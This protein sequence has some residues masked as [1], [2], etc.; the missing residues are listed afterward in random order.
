MKS[1]SL[2][3]RAASAHG[4]TK[5]GPPAACHSLEYSCGVEYTRT[6]FKTLLWY[7]TLKDYAVSW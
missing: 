2:E 6:S 7:K 3:L 1:T 5:S 4:S